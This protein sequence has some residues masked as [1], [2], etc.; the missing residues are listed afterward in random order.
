MQH[1]TKKNSCNREGYAGD[2][3]EGGDGRQLSCIT[4]IPVCFQDKSAGWVNRVEGSV[5]NRF[6][7][8]IFQTYALLPFG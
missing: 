1:T 4:Y 5:R 8:T 3:V 7:R 2:R 6:N